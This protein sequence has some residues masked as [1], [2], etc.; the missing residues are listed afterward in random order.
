MR[1]KP[2]KILLLLCVLPLVLWNCTDTFWFTEGNMEVEHENFTLQEAREFFNES[3][4]QLAVV[5]RS[6]QENGKTRLSAGEF[7]PD[8]DNS[9]ASAKNDLMC[10]DVPIDCE[11]TYKAVWLSTE[12]GT[13]T[14]EAVDVYQ[15]LVLVKNRVTGKLGQFLLTLIPDIAYERQHQGEVADLFINAGN[16]GG[17]TG[18][19]IYSIP[20]IDLIV[21]ANR[22]TNG[23]KTRGVHMSGNKK[24]LKENVFWLKAILRPFKLIRCSSVQSRGAGE[25]MIMEWVKQV[26]TVEKI[27]DC[28]VFSDENGEQFRMEDSDGDGE[29]DS[30]VILPEN[31][32]G[33]NTEPTPDPDPE[34]E[35]D[36]PKRCDRCG[37]IS[38]NGNCVTPGGGG[39]GGDDNNEI[40]KNQVTASQLTSAA[41]SAV[42]YIN[43]KYG[44][45]EANCNRGVIK[46]FEILFGDS[47]F[48]DLKANEMTEYWIDHP[49]AWQPI[50]MS[51]AQELANQGYFVVAGWINPDRTKSGHVVVV[52]PGEMQSGWG[53][54]VPCVMD[55][56]YK[57]RAESQKLSI[58]FHSKKRDGIIFFKYIKK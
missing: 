53:T 26:N 5:S 43:K 16:K 42:N 10:Y 34:D 37:L 54:K 50:P 58:S 48:Q 15:K 55:T 45:I 35:N 12:T 24:D 14:L 38:C 31:G 46:A 8:W 36:L 41:K 28:W 7:T 18:V 40:N 30:I 29:P 20:G 22:Y 11:H 21:R 13:P 25:D 49:D 33:E 52:V 32:N 39:S 17:F 47:E 27:G 6:M 56:G 57:M 4:M 3:T 2:R 51:Q 19:A 1:I 44:K 9:V 23:I